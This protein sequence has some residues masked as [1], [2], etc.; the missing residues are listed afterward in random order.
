MEYYSALSIEGNF[1]M[2][3]NMNEIWGHYSNW[4]SQSIKQIL[5]NSTYMKYLELSKTDTE[6]KMMVPRA[7]GKGEWVVIV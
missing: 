7:W 3:Y 4:I 5:Y 6:S 2:C 1:V